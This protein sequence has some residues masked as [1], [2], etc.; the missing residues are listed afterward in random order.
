M[1]WP[2][3]KKE[4]P[5]Q[6]F[7][8]PIPVIAPGYSWSYSLG[9]SP[10]SQNSVVNAAIG[11][12]SRYLASSIISLVDPKG[13][14][15][16]NH[17]VLDLLED[18]NPLFTADDIYHRLV[19]DI[20]DTG[21]AYLLIDSDGRNVPKTLSYVSPGQVSLDTSS[22]VYT[23]NRSGARPLQVNSD[24]VIHYKHQVDPLTGLGVS[25]LSSSSQDLWLD[26]D[27]TT[28]A[29]AMLRNN[30]VISLVIKPKEGNTIDKDTAEI[31]SRDL[32]RRS[33]GESRGSIIVLR[34]GDIEISPIAAPD[35]SKMAPQ[36]LR[37]MA[38]E[39]ICAVLGIPPIVLG[40]DL[41][42]SSSYANLA[43]A[44]QIALE[45]C[46][47]PWLSKFATAARSLLPYFILD[48][49]GWKIEY[50]EDANNVLRD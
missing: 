49:S 38:A 17:P 24:R 23:I 50:T 13:N 1:K 32:S 12:I 11:Y 29:T 22:L 37:A 19:K 10:P 6:F 25:P 28:Y 40:L 15:I 35:V 18:P 34:S 48:S 3:S 8:N 30:G 2:W 7:D 45:S 33:T 43:T 44:R 14:R 20:I 27:A 47:V 46:I 16:L 5:N 9:A 41:R 42:E 4:A 21:N 26:R 39:R 36:A 31:L